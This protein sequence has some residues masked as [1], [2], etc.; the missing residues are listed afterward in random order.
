MPEEIRKV[1]VFRWGQR[2]LNTFSPQFS[3]DE[4]G[5]WS[6]AQDTALVISGLGCLCEHALHLES[7]MMCAVCARH[8]AG[9]VKV[10]EPREV[11]TF[12]GR[13]FGTFNLPRADLGQEL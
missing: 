5:T 12:V 11:D 4:R 9:L 10:I 3:L 7:V 13:L 8:W 6:Q 2:T 1:K